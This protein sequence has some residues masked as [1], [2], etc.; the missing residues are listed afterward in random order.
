M[1]RIQL[2]QPSFT[3][4]FARSIGESAAPEL[5]PNHAWI[6][7][8]GNQGNVLFDATG[9]NNLVTLS[10]G[11]SWGRGNVTFD[12][13]TGIGTAKRP[14]STSFTVIVDIVPLN[15]TDHKRIL[16]C[17]STGSVSDLKFEI[18]RYQF[19]GSGFTIYPSSAA[20]TI[21]KRAVVAIQFQ[22]AV[23]ARLFLNGILLLTDSTI[24]AFTPTVFYIARRSNTGTDAYGNFTLNS[25][26][27]YNQILSPLQVLTLSRDPLLPFR[28]RSVTPYFFVPSSAGTEIALTGTSSISSAI[29][30][31]GT[32]TANQVIPKILTGVASIAD[33]PATAGVV[34]AVSTVSQELT[35]TASIASSEAVAG[36][37]TA[38]QVIA[39]ALTGSASVSE[40]LATAG[41]VTTDTVISQALTGAASIASSEATAGTIT[42][43]QIIAQTLTGAAS[44]AGGISTPGTVINGAAIAQE[45]TGTASISGSPATA[46]SVMAGQV[47]PQTLTGT[48]SI[49]GSEATAG[50]V[51]VEQII[52]QVLSGTL[53]VSESPATVGS[54]TLGAVLSGSEAIAEA[55]ATPGREHHTGIASPQILTG[56]A[57][58]SDSP[59]RAGIAF[60]G[61]KIKDHSISQNVVISEQLK[62]KVIS[63]QYQSLQ[64]S[65]KYQATRR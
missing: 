11:Y 45:L 17:G 48:E 5:W 58:L 55:I 13:S 35:G 59:A 52:A 22:S 28:R 36:S 60:W 51:T 39:Q 61:K 30:T 64:Q 1:G 49:A 19:E 33:S 29:A 10:G 15:L 57:S 50:T 38:G 4:G 34:V 43:E 20:A 40:S 21:G 65:I 37:V 14:L 63:E 3:N 9:N 23:L 32:V 53:S 26:L 46:G 8:L 7:A 42:V 41:T 54:I 62:I 24:S 31:A 6:P 47:I 16:G 18:G 12:G 44:I 56:T 27:A 25:I 2:L